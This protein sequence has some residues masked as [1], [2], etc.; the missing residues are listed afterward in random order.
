[1]TRTLTLDSESTVDWSAIRRH[2][3]VGKKLN[4]QSHCPSTG[5][6]FFR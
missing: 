2:T 4:G 3:F 1:M 5:L 6:Y